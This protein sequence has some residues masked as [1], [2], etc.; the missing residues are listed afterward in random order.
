M[1]WV[2]DLGSQ[3]AKGSGRVGEAMAGGAHVGSA[4]EARERERARAR[5]SASTPEMIHFFYEWER[6][7][8]GHE[9]KSPTILLSYL[10]FP[11]LVSSFVLIFPLVFLIYIGVRM[12]V[13]LHSQ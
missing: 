7:L 9:F 1:V 4:W 3:E 6:C 5:A 10:S 11:R 2:F 13:S 8:V 12:L